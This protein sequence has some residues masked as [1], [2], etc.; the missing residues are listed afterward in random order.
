VRRLLLLTSLSLVLA[1]TLAP[2]TLADQHE[3]VQEGPPLTASPTPTP[4]ATVTPTATNAAAAQYDGGKKVVLPE[5]G[6]A[7]S[8]AL[9]AGALLA[10]GGVMSFALVRRR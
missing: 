4:T 1:L 9:M 8:F 7:G 10:V 6:G 2:M 5:T 3:D